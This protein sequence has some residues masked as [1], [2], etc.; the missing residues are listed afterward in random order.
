[1]DARTEVI[2]KVTRLVAVRFDGDWRD[3]FDE[4]DHNGDGKINGEELTKMLAE[5]GVGSRLTRSMWVRGVIESMDGDL[6]QCISWD[7]FQAAMRT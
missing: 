6:D 3:A 1:M 7:E 5:A 4:Y 2:E